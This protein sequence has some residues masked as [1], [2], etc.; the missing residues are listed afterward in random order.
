MRLRPVVEESLFLG[1]YLGIF[2]NK[3]L[4]E[5][6]AREDFAPSR[7]GCIP[8]FPD[9]V[10]LLIDAARSPNASPAAGIRWRWRIGNGERRACSFGQVHIQRT[11]P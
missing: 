11:R 7:G 5:A 3:F 4:S 10:S 6:T 1:C 8:V 9:H 2:N